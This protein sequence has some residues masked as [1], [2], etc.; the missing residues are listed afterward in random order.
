MT[1]VTAMAD[2]AEVA[3]AKAKSK[4]RKRPAE[5]TLEWLRKHGALCH[6]MEKWN[7]HAGPMRRDGSGQR[8]GIR[9]DA[10]GLVDI[11]VLWN[12]ETH[13]VQACGVDVA[14]HFTKIESSVDLQARLARILSD[15]PK[16]RF[17]MICWRE[18]KLKD[19]RPEWVVRVIEYKMSKESVLGMPPEIMRFEMSPETYLKLVS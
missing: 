18:R 8:V 1:P 16:R 14:S 13:F 19:K 2:L 5:R 12:G 3:E 7:Q 4:K 10:W 11:L 6:M 17:F 9:Q 15:W